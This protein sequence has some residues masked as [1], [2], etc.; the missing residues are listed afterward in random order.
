MPSISSNSALASSWVCSACL[1]EL[2]AATLCRTKMID[3]STS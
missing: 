2:A 3:N 1:S